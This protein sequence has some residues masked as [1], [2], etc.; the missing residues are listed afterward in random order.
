MFRKVRG[1][2]CDNPLLAAGLAVVLSSSLLV[3]AVGGGSALFW[4]QLLVVGGVLLL[5]F[6]RRQSLTRIVFLAMIGLFLSGCIYLA[7]SD[8]GGWILCLTTPR[9]HFWMIGGAILLF[10]MGGALRT[11]NTKTII[12]SAAVVVAAAASAP[13]FVAPRSIL[14]ERSD[15]E[16]D[17]LGIVSNKKSF[18]LLETEE[19]GVSVAVPGGA[20]TPWFSRHGNLFRGVEI[21]P[22][23]VI[24]GVLP[25]GGQFLPIR[26]ADRRIAAW[27]YLGG[28][29]GSISPLDHVRTSILNYGFH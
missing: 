21:R 29:G 11:K 15:V 26:N 10:L 24:A 1:A 2:L 4:G 16:T 12:A 27:T 13:F 9:V 23:V 6:G 7:L 8:E 19:P 25:A 22:G 28:T 14:L 5:V 18:F 17:T 3:F 20:G